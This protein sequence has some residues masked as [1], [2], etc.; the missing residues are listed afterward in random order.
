[1]ARALCGEVLEIVKTKKSGC[2][3]RLSFD[4]TCV[5][6]GMISSVL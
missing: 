6:L 5:L 4:D 3:I 1:M 2:I